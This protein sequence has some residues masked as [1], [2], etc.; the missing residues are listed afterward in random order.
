[1]AE[2]IQAQG[3]RIGETSTNGEA[4]NH[5]TRRLAKMN[6]AIRGIATQIAHSD[7]FHHDR[8]PNLT[9]D[10]VLANPPFNDSDWRGELLGHDKS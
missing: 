4:L 9:A 5:P 10:V 3:G 7:T 2:V 6:L 8:F 1:M